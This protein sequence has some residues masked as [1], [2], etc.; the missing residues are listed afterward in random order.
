MPVHLFRVTITFNPLNPDPLQKIILISDDFKIDAVL[1]NRQLPIPQGIA[2]IVF[3]LITLP[4]GAASPAEFASTPLT[5]FSADSPPS[6][7]DMP[8][9]FLMQAFHPD[10]LTLVDFNT[11]KAR[12]SHPFNVNILYDGVLFSSDPMIVNEPP[13]QPGQG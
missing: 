9:T 4:G 7:I 3:D 2:L 12:N 8:T 1:N 10:H 5:W 13:V 11:V 6:E